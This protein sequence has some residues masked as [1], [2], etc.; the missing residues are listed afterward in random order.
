MRELAVR[1]RHHTSL[2][3]QT[4]IA[5]CVVSL[6]PFLIGQLVSNRKLSVAIQEHSAEQ[7]RLSLEQLETSLDI[8]MSFYDDILYQIYADRDIAYLI[9]ALTD[10]PDNAKLITELAEKLSIATFAKSYIC[11]VSVIYEDG[12]KIFYD[13]FFNSK[14]DSALINELNTPA[15][16]RQVMSNPYTTYLPI[17]YA[18]NTLFE[19]VPVFHMAHASFNFQQIDEHNAMIIMSMKE[20]LLSDLINGEY[21]HDPTLLR[22]ITDASG[23]ILSITDKDLLGET[24]PDGDVLSFAQH[25]GLMTSSYCSVVSVKNEQTGWMIYQVQDL[26]PLRAQ[27]SEQQHVMI[28]VLLISAVVLISAIILLTKMLLRSISVIA[29]VMKRVGMGDM[30]ARVPM[31]P[32]M[33]EEASMIASTFNQTMDQVT[34]MMDEVH[35]SA[36]RQ[37]NAEIIAMEAQLNPHFLYN[38]LDVINWMA[39]ERGAYDISNAVASLARIL[40]YGIDRSNT[41]VSVAQ[42]VKWINH[43]LNLW[44]IR[45]KQQLEFHLNVDESALTFPIHKLLF[46]PFV[47]NV[48]LHAFTGVDRIHVLDIG[49]HMEADSLRVIIRDNGRGMTEQQIQTLFHADEFNDRHHLGVHLAL[50]RMRYYYGDSARVTV[51]SELDVGTSIMIQLPLNFAGGGGYEI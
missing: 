3:K 50:E 11:A 10:D 24:I 36:E 41:V 51:E 26:S 48:L 43:Y 18:M 14:R 29:D 9:N 31:E 28:T 1:K 21:P 22:L 30:D 49:I 46:Q 38:T 13:R 17:S 39:I 47:E 40:R 32:T 20:T 7:A 42:E 16:Y 12:T 37:R 19:K 34:A 35:Q 33:P 6:L 8:T 2:R 23:N 25:H 27:L 4:I 5:V 45:L 15:L 44:Q